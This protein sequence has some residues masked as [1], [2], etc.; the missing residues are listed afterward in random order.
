MIDIPL[1][2]QFSVAASA[3]NCSIGAM[4][5]GG[6]CLGRQGSWPADRRLKKPQRCGFFSRR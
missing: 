2:E 6:G 4:L 1:I 5:A 3:V